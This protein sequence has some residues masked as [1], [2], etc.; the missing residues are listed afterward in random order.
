MPI[1]VLIAATLQLLLAVTFLV[2]PVAV[3]K[4]GGVAQRAAEAEVVRQGRPPEVLARHGIRFKEEVWEFALALGIAA[5][6]TVLGSLNLAGIGAGR[7][8]SWILE[9]VVLVGVGLVTIGQVFAARYTE[10]MFSKSDDAAVRDLDGRAVIAA[11][12]ARFPF[13]V[14]PLVLVRF[15]LATLGSFLVIVLLSTPA[16]GTHFR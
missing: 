11:A 8:L 7:V 3:W 9:P 2:I 13:W 1:A 10:A 5:T 4:T 16:A 12:S 14:R 6:P 15:S